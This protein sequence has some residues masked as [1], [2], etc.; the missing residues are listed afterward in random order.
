MLSSLLRNTILFIAATAAVKH[1]HI[2]GWIGWV[3][4]LGSSSGSSSP[5][6]DKSAD[7]NFGMMRVLGWRLGLS[8]TIRSFLLVSKQLA[9]LCVS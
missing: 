2:F 5:P 6:T 9:R 4:G 7:R 8:H 3:D 1:R